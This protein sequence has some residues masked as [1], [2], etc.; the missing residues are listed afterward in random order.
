M[1]TLSTTPFPLVRTCLLLTYPS[2]FADVLYGWPP[3]YMQN[4]EPE[5]YFGVQNCLNQDGKTINTRHIIIL[6]FENVTFF[7]AKLGSNICSWVDDQTFLATPTVWN[8]LCSM[9]DRLNRIYNYATCVP[10]TE[11]TARELLLSLSKYFLKLFLHLNT[12]SNFHQIWSY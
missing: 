10:L 12:T 6:Y 8:S 2:L 11:L 5:D 3:N 9:R 1:S 7:H 4:L